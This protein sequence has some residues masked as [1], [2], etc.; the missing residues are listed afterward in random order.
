MDSSVHPLIRDF[1]IDCVKDS[2][3]IYNKKHASYKNP[4][5]KKSVFAKISSEIFRLYNRNLSGNQAILYHILREYKYQ[6]ERS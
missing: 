4:L 2:P 1:I 6:N 5:A 3:F